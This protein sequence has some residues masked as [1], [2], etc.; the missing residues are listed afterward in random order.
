M[1]TIQFLR[2][3]QTYEDRLKYS[4]PPLLPNMHED[5]VLLVEY[6]DGPDGERNNPV[7]CSYAN[8][9]RWDDHNST[10]IRHDLFLL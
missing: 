7:W 5:A 8:A 1:V 6:L 4:V 2:Q 9:A 3:P 10:F